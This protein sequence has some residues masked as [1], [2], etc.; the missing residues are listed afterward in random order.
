MPTR[1]KTNHAKIIN[2]SP[3]IILQRKRGVALLR[4]FGQSGMLDKISKIILD[5][6]QLDAKGIM[7][8]YSTVLL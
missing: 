5:H 1:Y 8:K 6:C 2:R 4:P 3:V 7:K